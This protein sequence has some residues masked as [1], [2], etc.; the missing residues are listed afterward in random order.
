MKK[1]IIIAVIIILAL[2]LLVPI[3]N[4]LK[5]GGTVEY[6]ALTY[7]ISK[8]HRLNH[9]SESG[10]ED[11]LIIELLGFEI[12]NN[13]NNSMQDDSITKN[14]RQEEIEW[15]EISNNGVDEELLFKNVNTENLEKVASLLQALSSEI[16]EKEKEDYEFYFLAKWYDYTLNSKQYNEVINMGNDAVKPLYLIIYKSPNQG[17]Y[18]YICSMALEELSGFEFD[19]ETETWATSKQFLELFN[20]KVIESRER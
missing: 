13:V 2:I 12:Y 1:K 17:S 19:K 8:V 9:N 20:K 6:K 3:P 16:A 14:D 10:Y 11:G 5:D 4:H 7:K 15:N 18:E